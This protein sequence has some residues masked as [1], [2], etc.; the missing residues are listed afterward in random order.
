MSNESFDKVTMVIPT[1]NRC[2]FLLRLLSFYRSY[3]FPARILVLDS[4][5]N[6]NKEINRRTIS[7]FADLNISH[8]DHYCSL[9]SD[10]CT[11]T[12]DAINY[13]DTR[14]TVICADDDLVAP[15][16]IKQSVNFLEKNPDFTIA[17][18]YYI[19]FYVRTD[20]RKMQ[21]FYWTPI[22]PFKS[23]TF[24]DAKTRLNFHL[25]NYYPTFYA[26]HRTN[27]LN[28]IFEETLKYTDDIR[29][30]ELLPSM[31]TSIY[32]KMKRLDVFYAAR[33]NIPDSSS[34]TY[35]RFRDFITAET[36]DEK[37]TKFREC[38]AIHLSKKSQLDIPEAKKAVDDA[39]SFYLSTRIM[40]KESNKN[41]LD[42]LKSPRRMRKAVKSLCRKIFLLKQTKKGGFKETT[43][44]ASKYSDDFNKIRLH[45]LSYSKE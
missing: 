37:Y 1:F 31:I 28:M 36:W 18:G 23:I 41:I 15:N 42:Y 3:N 4:S 45:V 19:S 27:F 32:G 44:I 11:K 26:I 14:Y 35:G 38:L 9:D 33:E 39:M 10:P 20:E 13:I 24:P 30:S 6:Q 12:I 40:K 2:H 25:S 5:S 21:R 22:Y 43:D 17:H 8:F 34:R 7:S 16:G 29:F